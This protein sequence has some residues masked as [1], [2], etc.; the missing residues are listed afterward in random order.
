MTMP[1]IK[2]FRDVVPNPREPHELPSTD[3]TAPFHLFGTPFVL[4]RGKLAF[5]C[6]F[7]RPTDRGG[8]HVF[9][10]TPWRREAILA[11]SLGATLSSLTTL[12]GCVASVVRMVGPV[13][14]DRLRR[15]RNRMP[16]CAAGAIGSLVNRI[17]LENPGSEVAPHK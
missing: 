9:S 11:R 15:P 5:N 17:S 3:R 7:Q 14:H 2:V 6:G 10:A 4:D 13:T 8:N 12:T 16:I 1:P